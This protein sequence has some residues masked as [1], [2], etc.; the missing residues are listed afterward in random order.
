MCYTPIREHITGQA[1]VRAFT[2]VKDFKDA[3][4]VYVYKRVGPH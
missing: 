3:G 2:C 1:A 4:S